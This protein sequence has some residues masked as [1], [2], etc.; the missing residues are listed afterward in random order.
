MPPFQT[1]ESWFYAML[2][3][4]LYPLVAAVPS[5]VDYITWQQIETTG[6]SMPR[7]RAGHAATLAL[8]K[9][10]NKLYSYGGIASGVGTGV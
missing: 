6:Q 7:A 4:K 3:L 5:D 9:L 10:T 2:L 8:V 1:C